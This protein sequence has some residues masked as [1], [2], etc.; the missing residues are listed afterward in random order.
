VAAGSSP[1]PRRI[2]GWKGHDK[3]E[4]GKAGIDATDQ[5][6]GP[7]EKESTVDQEPASPREPEKIPL[8]GAIFGRGRAKEKKGGDQ[9]GG[10]AV[11]ITIK[12]GS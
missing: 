11:P 8:R 3:Y 9:E 5:T 4:K 2:E 7:K 6:A 10:R 1:Q 12:R